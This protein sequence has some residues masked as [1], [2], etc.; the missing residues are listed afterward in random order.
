MSTV[1]TTASLN[2][3]AAQGTVPPDDFTACPERVVEVADVPLDVPNFAAAV[4]Q[5]IG[6][7]F[8]DEARVEDALV[9][10]VIGNVIFAG[11]PGTGKT[12]LAGLLAK[13]FNVVLCSETANPEWSVYDVIGSQSLN[14]QG[15]VQPKHGIVTRAILDCAATTVRNLDKG[16]GP[17][18][19]WLL[20][21]EMNRAEI[22]R[23]F[24]PLFTALS[25]DDK[26]TFSLDYVDGAPRITIPKR[27]RI[28]CT[29]NDYDTRFVNSMSGA[30]RRRFA[31]VLVL[32][33]ENVEG[34]VPEAE[35]ALAIDSAEKMILS[36]LG[37]IEE[38]GRAALESRVVQLRK[39]FGG[40]RKLDMLD[41]IA[42]G[43]SQVIDCCTYA[44]AYVATGS[45]PP[46]SD[47]AWNQ[48][49]DRVLETRLISGLETDSTRIRL[50]DGYVD[51]LAK[52]FP[53]LPRTTTRLRKFLHGSI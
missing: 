14:A 30:L 18:G 10:L 13:A 17:Q 16:Q 50:T 32:P 21:D 53:M 5:I 31:R 6:Q 9:S 37:K 28:L 20:I 33:P 48:L 44:M 15:G 45:A 11:P 49:L 34:M 52:T 35:I 19:N 43:T 39:I 8:Y 47:D 25:G 42:I 41:G 36:R 27:F 29:M 3:L 51:A 40:V 24:G 4:S 46:A 1:E 12:M 23:A 2:A 22:D 26:G 7:G 38:T